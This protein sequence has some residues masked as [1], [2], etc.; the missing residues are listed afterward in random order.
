MVKGKNGNH[1]SL[2]FYENEFVIY[3]EKTKTRIGTYVKTR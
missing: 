3:N 1:V 2:N